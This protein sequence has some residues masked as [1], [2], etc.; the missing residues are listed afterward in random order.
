VCARSGRG[1]REEGGRGNHA[2]L[3]HH[4]VRLAGDSTD[5][6]QLPPP[7]EAE[8]RRDGS[9][10]GMDAPVIRNLVEVNKHAKNR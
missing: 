2:R 8:P 10:V 1:G 9:G 3:A 6:T 5:V 7:T 4:F